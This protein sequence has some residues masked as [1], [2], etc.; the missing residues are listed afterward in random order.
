[1]HGAK[2]KAVYEYM[3]KVQLTPQFMCKEKIKDKNPTNLKELAYCV[4]DVVNANERNI[5]HWINHAI[6]YYKLAKLRMLGLIDESYEIKEN[7]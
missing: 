6:L 1:M 4:H 5:P 2:E 7:L 3:T